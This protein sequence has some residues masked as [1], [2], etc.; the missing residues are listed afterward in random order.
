MS[1]F[2]N[3]VNRI[4]SGSRELLVGAF[5]RLYLLVLAPLYQRFVF[6]GAQVSGE[7]AADTSPWLGHLASQMGELTVTYFRSRLVLCLVVAIIAAVGFTF[8]GLPFGWLLGLLVGVLNFVP[9]LATI[10]GLPMSLIVTYLHF[11]DVAHPIYVLVVFAAVQLLET[12]ILAPLIQGKMVGLHPL[13]TLLLLLIGAHF[14]GILGL[15]LAIPLAA[16]LKILH[17]ELFEP[18]AR[19]GTPRHVKVTVISSEPE[20]KLGNG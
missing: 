20:R 13:T 10:I 16:G 18:K 5:R 4:A 3:H 15:L 1:F 6:P 9:F 19:P 12:F 7:P 17:H 11:N 2:R 14:A 8:T